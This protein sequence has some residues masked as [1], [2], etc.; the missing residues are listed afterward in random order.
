MRME[1]KLPQY[2]ELLDEAIVVQEECPGVQYICIE[3]RENRP[4]EYYIVDKNSPVISDEAKRYGKPFADR[5]DLLMYVLDDPAGGKA[6]IEYEIKKYRSANGLLK[7][8][9]ESLGDFT[10]YAAELNPE[11]FGILLPSHS[12]PA[13]NTLRW[14]SL[15][16]GIYLHETETCELIVSVCP[17][18]CDHD[19]S[20]YAH[21][22]GS[23]SEDR[24]FFREQDACVALFELAQS[25]PEL[26][27]SPLIDW[28]ALMTAIWKRYPAY[29][30]S[31]NLS[32]Q[33]GLHDPIANLLKA[34]GVECE[35]E[36]KPENMI[37]VSEDQGTKYLFFYCEKGEC[38][39]DAMA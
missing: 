17:P 31:F 37:E 23:K 16:N 12:T 33:S 34:L 22:L 38:E 20:E 32:E 10:P 18:L 27:A 15:M 4:M 1:N 8:E 35:A 9:D 3:R 36:S 30:I 26:K 13:G 11:Y 2:Q 19:F 39:T 14:R 28:P 25:Y 29:A 21:G 7:A 6:V 5:P 24:L